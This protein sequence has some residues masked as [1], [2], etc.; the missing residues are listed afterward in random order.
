MSYKVIEKNEFG[1]RVRNYSEF[2]DCDI[3]KYHKEKSNCK[4]IECAP[5]SYYLPDSEVEKLELENDL[6]AK[7]EEIENNLKQTIIDFVKW[8]REDDM[9]SYTPEHL[10]E[11]Y[12]KIKNQ[13]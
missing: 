4:M 3:C 2:R 10:A 7:N 8:Y 5:N 1:I 6:K 9:S 13:K 11:W 12:L